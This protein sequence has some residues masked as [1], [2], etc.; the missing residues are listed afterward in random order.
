[1]WNYLKPYWNVEKQIFEDVL[2]TDT[3]SLH[4]SKKVDNIPLGNELGQFKL[5]E[6]GTGE[7]FNVKDYQTEKAGRKVKGLPKNAVKKDENR[8]EYK[9]VLKMR[10][11]KKKGLKGIN[12][13]VRF[14]ELSEVYLKGNK[15][16]DGYMHPFVLDVY[17]EQ[18]DPDK[19]KRLTKRVLHYTEAPYERWKM[20]EF[21]KKESYSDLQ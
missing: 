21:L 2:Y 15:G 16:S 13:E 10:E 12:V 18:V 3:D 11:S 14:K 9:H 8:Y 5:T 19:V 6:L 20:R 4:F 1:M 7:H 17:K